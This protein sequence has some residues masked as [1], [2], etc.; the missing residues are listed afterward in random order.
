MAKKK[1]KGKVVQML[2]PENY[3]R[4]RSRSLPVHECWITASWQENKNASIVISRKH[5]NGNLTVGFYLV[6]LACLGV[7]DAYF[8]FNI[9]SY[10]YNEM[11]DYMT[12]DM[13]LERLDYPL[14]H[15][16]IFAAVEFAEEYGFKPTKDFTQTMQ[17]FLNEDND[18]VELM[19][20]ECGDGGVP[21]YVRGPFDSDAEAKRILA[22]LEKTAGPGNFKFIDKPDSLPFDDEDED[23]I[24]EDDDWEGRDD[25]IEN[26]GMDE[27]LALFVRLLDNMH[28]LG[29]EE[30][31]ELGDLTESIIAGFLDR[32]KSDDLYN[33]F[34][35][36][37]ARFEI[38]DEIT[39][40]FLF[41]SYPPAFDPSEIRMA[42]PRLYGQLHM[43]TK[44]TAKEVAKLQ[45][46]YP[47]TPALCFLELNVLRGNDLSAYRKKLSA[48]AELFPEY[49][50]IKILN[51]IGELNPEHFHDFSF[52]FEKAIEY[53]FGGR[54][55]VN[56]IEMFNLFMLLLF[57]AMASN[58]IEEIDAIDFLIE[59]FDFSDDDIELLDNFI[60]M[61]KL[62]FILW[63]LDDMD[64]PFTNDDELNGNDR[65]GAVAGLDFDEADLKKSQTFQFKIQLQGI[66]HPPV[67]RRV[68]VPSTY[69]FLHFHYLIQYAFG[70]TNTHLFQF[71]EKG[72]GSRTIITKTYDDGDF[73]DDNQVEAEGVKLSDVFKR[74]KQALIYIYDFG[75]SWEHKITLEKIIP[76]KTIQPD[77]LDGKGKCPPEDCGGVWGYSEL[78]DTLANPKHPEHKEMREWLGLGKKE[79]WDAHEFIIDEVREALKSVFSPDNR[80]GK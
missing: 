41:G 51:Q 30:K 5:T 63:K 14:A 69:S 58:H 1:Q 71:S 38:S 35:E 57:R 78:K 49:S 26:M 60:S 80:P 18:A 29:D 16:I 70:W 2:S 12:E 79:N 8:K 23:D 68:T 47:K 77:C 76:E 22:Q 43:N 9:P 36:E 17:Y 33:V 45:K 42:F 48:Y 11:L 31:E 52:S 34:L 39:D 59:E 32:D 19:E 54:K 46:K 6:D 7:K 28:K 50:P 74:E 10:E 55:Q 65:L 66:T 56:R 3:I 25:Q 75:D 13:V 20:I 24:F 72:F 37:L 53:F 15:N 21:M 44:K 40:E 4:Q 62:D 27:K 67:W 73:G 64:V 61:A